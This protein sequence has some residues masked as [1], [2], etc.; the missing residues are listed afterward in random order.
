M[1]TAS[2]KFSKDMNAITICW[3]DN[4]GKIRKVFHLIFKHEYLLSYGLH[5]IQMEYCTF[6]NEGNYV[7]NALKKRSL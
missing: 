4:H 7:S 2:A 1:Y 6:N 5:V 3:L